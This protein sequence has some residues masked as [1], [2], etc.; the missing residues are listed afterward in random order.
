MRCI[1]MIVAL[2]C[3][4]QGRAQLPVD[5]LLA[6]YFTEEAIALAQCRDPNSDWM[7]KEKSTLLYLNLLRTNPPRFAA[8]YRHYL[9]EHEAEVYQEKFLKNDRYY[10]SLYLELIGLEPMPR[11]YPDADLQ[12]L[13]VCWAEESG[14][15]GAIGHNRTHCPY[16]YQAE[17]T[18]FSYTDDPLINLLELLVDEGILDLGHRKMLLDARLEAVGISIRPH[19]RYNHCLVIDLATRGFVLATSR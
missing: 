16:G 9:R 5:E 13:A 8:F 15:S 7:D 12:D 11:L 4:G 2:L 1:L 10:A 6:K 18:C 17:S 14:Q 3:V 19:V